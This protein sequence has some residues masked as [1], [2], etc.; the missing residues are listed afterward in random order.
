M[1]YCVE[2]TVA[3]PVEDAVRVLP[4]PDVPLTVREL[5]VASP[6]TAATFWNVPLRLTP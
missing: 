3:R 2:V 1:E 5:K 6:F 4:G